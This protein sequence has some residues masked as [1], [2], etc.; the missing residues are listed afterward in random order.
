[1]LILSFYFSGGL[2]KLASSVSQLENNG[3]DKMKEKCGREAMEN[4][5]GDLGNK[6]E[7]NE[8]TAVEKSGSITKMEK[9]ETE[10]TEI[11]VGN[12]AI[13]G[14]TKYVNDPTSTPVSSFLKLM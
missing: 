14:V 3:S 1:M 11:R 12:M 7:K 9:D 10:R 13:D 6:F 5:G 2:R 4:G 8:K